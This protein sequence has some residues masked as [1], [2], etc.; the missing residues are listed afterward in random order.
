MT[1]N[2]L[3][4]VADMK[5]NLGIDKIKEIAN[6]ITDERNNY[7]LN[8][9]TPTAE[10]IES[11]AED[12]TYEVNGVDGNTIIGCNIAVGDLEFIVRQ[13]VE[14]GMFEIYARDSRTREYG[15]I[16]INSFNNIEIIAE[17]IN[18]NFD[19]T[20]YG[21]KLTSIGRFYKPNNNSKLNVLDDRGTETLVS[22]R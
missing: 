11:Y 9:L 7:F 15:S 13:T 3:N 2:E 1:A 12:E 22:E 17:Y 10:R 16:L 5:N 14:K 21:V 4:K 6:K 18:S 20:F 19:I 8:P